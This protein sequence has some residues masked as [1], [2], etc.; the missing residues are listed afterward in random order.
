[1]LDEY[2][3]GVTGTR[4]DEDIIYIDRWTGF[5]RRSGHVC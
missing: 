5:A 3:T 2:K 4:F 1:M